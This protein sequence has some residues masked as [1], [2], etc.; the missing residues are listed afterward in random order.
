LGVAKAGKEK[1]MSDGKY[2]IITVD[3]VTVATSRQIDAAFL[4]SPEQEF[5]IDAYVRVTAS[6][7]EEAMK[8]VDTAC[9]E[10]YEMSGIEVETFDA[11]GI[12]D[13]DGNEIRPVS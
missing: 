4:K 1:P 11:Y 8:L 2:T 12:N 9:A 3:G 6:S 5:V 10:L 7:Y 13:K